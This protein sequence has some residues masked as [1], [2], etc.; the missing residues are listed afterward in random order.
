MF[1][2][3]ADEQTNKSCPCRSGQA[4]DCC[5]VFVTPSPWASILFATRMGKLEASRIR[6]SGGPGSEND[7]SLLA[8]AH[9]AVR[10]ATRLVASSGHG[11]AGDERT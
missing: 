10:S 8:S 2:D 1:F 3:D 6:S 5:L 4:L 9:S 7:E 11:K